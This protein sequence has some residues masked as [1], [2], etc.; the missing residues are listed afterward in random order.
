[1]RTCILLTLFFV[2]NYNS[3]CKA[4]VLHP[5][6]ITKKHT[7]YYTIKNTNY[8]TE[9][10]YLKN[11]KKEGIWA[12]VIRFKDEYYLSYSFYKNNKYKNL[13]VS[14]KDSG[15][16]VVTIPGSL[17]KKSL[18]YQFDSGFIERISSERI[19]LVFTKGRLDYI[20]RNFY[21][22]INKTIKKTYH[23][24]K[25]LKSISKTKVA[26]EKCKGC[27]ETHAFEYFYGRQKNYNYNGELICVEKYRDGKLKRTI[28]KKR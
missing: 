9:F 20:E 26:V 15:S 23:P 28:E 24:N 8:S 21:F 12:Q 25:K 6:S 5:D 11:G 10:G 13:N 1:M 17:F 19:T 16:R 22:G 2:F 7:G 3:N 4:Q 27:W 14:G 18:I